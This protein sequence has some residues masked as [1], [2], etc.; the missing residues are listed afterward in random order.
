MI[1]FWMK[2]HLVSG[3]NCNP[4]NLLTPQKFTRN[5]NNVG[6]TFSVGDNKP[7]FTIRIGDTTISYLGYPSYL[8]SKSYSQ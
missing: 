4:V 6:I 8:N 3:S 1:E 5:D 2:N 7:Q